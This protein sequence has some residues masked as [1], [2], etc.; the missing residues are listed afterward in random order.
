MTKEFLM[1]D[2]RK[3]TR[4][5]TEALRLFSQEQLNQ[6]PFPGSWTPGQVGQHL[7]KSETGVT[8]LLRGNTQRAIRQ[9]DA[10]HE[11]IRSLF[12]DFS[13]KMEAPEFIIPDNHPKNREQLIRSLEE[14]R[15]NVLQA[16]AEQ[17]LDLLLTD[18]D[19]PDWGPLSGQEWLTFMTVHSRRH[20][21]QLHKI[22]R[23]LQG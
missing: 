13:T 23:H 21:H 19:M 20:T 17:D 18:F 16:A 6:V 5:L 8:E 22:H 14:N 7:L 9:P 10:H 3:S 12:L 11:N 2:L 4:E 1:E 15:E